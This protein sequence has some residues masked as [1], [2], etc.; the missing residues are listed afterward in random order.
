MTDM[1]PTDADLTPRAW[2]EALALIALFQRA[3][4]IDQPM[5]ADE[6]ATFQGTVNSVPA[7]N[8]EIAYCLLVE[9][10][11]D[12]IAAIHRVDGTSVLNDRLRKLANID[13]FE[14]DPTR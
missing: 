7:A 9:M 13:P 2:Q 5:T 14:D 12:E 6:T 3:R 8:L 10:L 11:V 1:D 4:R